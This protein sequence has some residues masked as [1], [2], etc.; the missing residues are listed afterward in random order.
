MVTYDYNCAS[1]E[2]TEEHF[3]SMSKNPKITCSQCDH[4]MTKL[5]SGG[6][7][8]VG[9]GIKESLADHKE[10]EH[11]KKVKDPERA[12]R[13]RKKAFGKDA[14]GDPSMQTDPMHIVKRGRTL[15]G[16]EK[17]IDKGEMVRA[18]ARDDYAVQKAQEALKKSQK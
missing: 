3:H 1:C 2:I 16:Q 14:V 7:Y 18:L 17:D 9:S 15:G 13:M 6:S 4:A 11:T 8:I 12:V 10:S 5:I